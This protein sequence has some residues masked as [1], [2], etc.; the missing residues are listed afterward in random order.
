MGIVITFCFYIG[1]SLAEVIGSP[2]GFPFIEVFYKATGTVR[3]ATGMTVFIVAKYIST[4]LAGV[5]TASR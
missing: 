3:G 4:N 5:A 1:D 2:T